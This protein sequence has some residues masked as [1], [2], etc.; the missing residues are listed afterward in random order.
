[1][2]LLFN[3]ELYSNIFTSIVQFPYRVK[4]PVGI[5]NFNEI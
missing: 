5:L 3:F 4:K 1:M 2:E